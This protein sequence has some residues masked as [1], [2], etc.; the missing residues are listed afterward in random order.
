M[1]IQALL[2]LGAESFKNS[3][4]SGDAGSGL[5]IGSL[6][7][8]L[9]G[10]TGGSQGGLDISSLVGL[11]QN[12]GMGDLLQSWLGDGQNQAISGDQVKSLLDSDQISS[13]ASQLGLSEDEAVGGLQDA[14]PQMMD[15]A[16][17]G[18]NLLDSL[19]GAKGMMGLAGKLFG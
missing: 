5:D 13:F 12:K 7:S 18:G 4:G 6:T 17:Q 14:L 2:K 8:A 16:S 19:G 3:Q 10:L 11:M 9:S 15:H 1:D